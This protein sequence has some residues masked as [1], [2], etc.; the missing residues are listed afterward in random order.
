LESALADWQK[1]THPK[2]PKATKAV[3]NDFRMI[4]PVE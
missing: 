3:V 2:K 1:P 4:K